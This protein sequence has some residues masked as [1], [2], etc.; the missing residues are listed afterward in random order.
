MNY[1]ETLVRD[2]YHQDYEMDGG[3]WGALDVFIDNFGGSEAAVAL[4]RE[5]DRLFEASG[6]DDDRVSDHIAKLGIQIMPSASE[7][8]YAGWLRQVRARAENMLLAQPG[9]RREDRDD[10]E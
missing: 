5:I 9:G 3:R 1:L 8:N 7:K 2:Y 4:I 6:S 10:A